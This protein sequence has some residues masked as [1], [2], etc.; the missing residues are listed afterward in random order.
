MSLHQVDRGRVWATG[1]I[2]APDLHRL[3]SIPAAWLL[4]LLSLCSVA[5]YDHHNLPSSSLLRAPGYAAAAKELATAAGPLRQPFVLLGLKRRLQPFFSSVTLAALAA[6]PSDLGLV[7]ALVLPYLLLLLVG[8]RLL[9]RWLRATAP[10]QQQADSSSSGS[11]S[12]ST[13]NHVQ[14]SALAAAVSRAVDLFC[15]PAGAAAYLAVA[16]LLPAVCSMH[17]LVAYCLGLQLRSPSSQALQLMHPLSPLLAAAL[18]LLSQVG[19][20]SVRVLR[21]E[22][23]QVILQECQQVT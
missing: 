9:Q 20:F 16:K 22:C 8:T 12:S 1:P 11:S 2:L 3:L 5:V 7:A 15:G 17:T 23:Q 21:P 14:P 10:A 19:T 4:A 6:H 18:T 13:A